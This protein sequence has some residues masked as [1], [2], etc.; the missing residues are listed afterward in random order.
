MWLAAL[1]SIATAITA[2]RRQPQ[3]VF[4]VQDAPSGP[5]KKQT[6][7]EAFARYHY[8][9]N[10]GWIEADDGVGRVIVANARLDIQRMLSA[11]KAR[12]KTQRDKEHFEKYATRYEQYLA[13]TMYD[14]AFRV[15]KD[16]AVTYAGAAITEFNGTDSV[17]RHVTWEEATKMIQS[18]YDDVFPI[19]VENAIRDKYP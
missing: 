7:K 17:V 12:A 13:M 19:W 4:L 6:I 1:V 8:F 9:R 18:V 16:K 10:T 15:G 3:P 2:C 14:F 5:D 11:I